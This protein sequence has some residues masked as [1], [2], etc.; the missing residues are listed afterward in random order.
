MGVSLASSLLATIITQMILTL[1]SGRR[2]EA[3][4]SAQYGGLLKSTFHSLRMPWDSQGLQP[5]P[6]CTPQLTACKASLP[7][8]QTGQETGNL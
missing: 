8:S 1:R 4:R 2:I 5:S 6:T 3:L 7:E